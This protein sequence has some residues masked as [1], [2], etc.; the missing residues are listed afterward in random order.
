MAPYPP[1]KK[2]PKLLWGNGLKLSGTVL[3]PGTVWTLSVGIKPEGP[4][5]LLKRIKVKYVNRSGDAY[6]S[7]TA[8]AF[9]I[10]G[11]CFDGHEWP[12]DYGAP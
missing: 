6:E 8:E 2:D 9:M 5:G 10:R 4:L 11:D 12:A 7:Q 3:E 1:S